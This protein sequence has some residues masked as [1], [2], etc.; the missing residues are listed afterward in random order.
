M[1]KMHFGGKKREDVG[2]DRPPMKGVKS[3][4][5]KEGL[6]GPRVFCDFPRETR[7]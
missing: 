2:E 3:S 1:E 4:F 7:V 6:G 5:S